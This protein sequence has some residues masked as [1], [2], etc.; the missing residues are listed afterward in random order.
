VQ[1]ARDLVDGTGDTPGFIDVDPAEVLSYIADD[2]PFAQVRQPPAAQPQ[3]QTLGSGSVLQ[4]S[5]LASSWMH[6]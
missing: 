6:K 2:L 1:T 3:T 5:R 4:L